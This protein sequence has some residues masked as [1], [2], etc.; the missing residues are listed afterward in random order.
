MNL[1]L[2]YAKALFETERPN[3]ARVLSALKR[4]GHGKLISRIAAEYEKLQLQD[5]RREM[6][7][8]VTPKSERTRT[9]LHLYRKLIAN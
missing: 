1:A 2:R 8:R 6:H 4:R 3:S 5:A 9:L 7:A